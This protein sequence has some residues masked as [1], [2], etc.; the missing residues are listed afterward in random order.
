[1]VSASV[2]DVTKLNVNFLSIS[3]SSFT[4][5]LLERA[6]TRNMQLAVWTVNTEDDMFRLMV[7]G[8][9][10]IVTDDPETAIRVA[11]QYHELSELELLLI[12]LREWLSK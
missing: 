6:Q 8:A 9:E 5:E 11:K 7:A 1:M 10:L 4:A 2:G 3:K 12:R